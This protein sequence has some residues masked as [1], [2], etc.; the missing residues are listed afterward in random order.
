MPTARAPCSV[1]SV[2]RSVCCACAVAQQP[3]SVA[4]AH[5]MVAEQPSLSLL[6]RTAAAGTKPRRSF[7]P[8]SVL[9]VAPGARHAVAPSEH[10]KYRACRI[11][12]N[13]TCDRICALRL[14]SPSLRC[15]LRDS[16][17]TAAGRSAAPR[18][19]VGLLR[20]RRDGLN[21]HRAGVTGAAARRRHQP[22][23][24]EAVVLAV[25]RGLVR[26]C[27]GPRTTRTRTRA[28]FARTHARAHPRARSHTR[29]HTHTGAQA[30]ANTHNRHPT[31]HSHA[32]AHTARTQPQ[33]HAHARTH[34]QPQARA[35]AR[36]HAR[37]C[38]RAHAC[39]RA[40]THALT[41]SRTH[42]H[43]HRHTRSITQSLTHTRARVRAHA[44]SLTRSRAHTG[45]RLRRRLPCAR[46]VRRR[47]A[48][49]AATRPP[50]STKS[51]AART[52][53]MMRSCAPP[54]TRHSALLSRRRFRPALLS[55]VSLFSLSSPFSHS[56]SS[57]LAFCFSL[58]PSLRLSFFC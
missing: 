12:P 45:T 30:G 56:F 8:P 51:R 37:T 22:H 21:D 42:T 11:P 20:R 40:H 32:R 43:T 55:F 27:L 10:A 15:R 44:H 33:T 17:A 52:T 39:V 3:L 28:T 38:K 47:S 16:R 35:R 50:R 53:S 19:R 48:S 31:P 9:R 57:S 36:T 34:A 26:P 1:V 7:G 18:G 2:S 6:M 4:L 14:W 5:A 54:P 23:A 41:H 24:T 58:P 49:R 46:A 13:V 25:R 29:T